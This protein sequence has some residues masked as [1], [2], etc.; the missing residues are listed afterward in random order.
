M[1]ILLRL[2]YRVSEE[3][4]F[5]VTVVVTTMAFPTFTTIFVVRGQ[6]P[7]LD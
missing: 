4:Q 6:E 1:V 3:M 7:S 2:W 5:S